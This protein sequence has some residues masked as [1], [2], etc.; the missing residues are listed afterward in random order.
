MTTLTGCDI[1]CKRSDRGVGSD[2]Y[3]RQSDAWCTSARMEPPKS[4]N[5]TVKWA[6]EKDNTVPSPPNNG[7]LER[8]E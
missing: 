1:R 2:G 6:I 5:G 3:F 4:G 7:E 8:K